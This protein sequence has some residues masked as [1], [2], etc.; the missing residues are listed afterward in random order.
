M[1]ERHRVLIRQA[2][3]DNSLESVVE[4]IF[5]AFPVNVAGKRVLVKPNILA[6]REPDKAVTTHPAVVSAVIRSLEKRRA[7]EIIVGDNGGMT[8]YGTNE[9][10][11]AKSGLLEA[12]GKHYRNLGASPV[13]VPLHNPYAYD[14]AIS[15]EILDCD[16]LVS[17]PKFKTHTLTMISCAIKNSYGFLLG[18]E[19]ARL[20]R[21]AKSKDAFARTIVDVFS[22][23]M[24]DLVICDGIL[25]MQ[26]NGPSSKDV[27]HLGRLLASTDA[28]ALDAVVGAMMGLRPSEVRTTVEAAGRGLGIADIEALEIDGAVTPIEGFKLPGTLLRGRVVDWLA[29]FISGAIVSEPRPDE[30]TC[31]RCGLC[32]DHCPTEAIRMDPY[33]KIAREKCIRCY[34]C[35]EFCPHDAMKLSRR[36]RFIRRLAR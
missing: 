11:A 28:V 8:E 2:E 21:V 26:G 1:P 23:R 35:L 16:V 4:E 10:A 13:R 19:K 20:H 36:V 22:L 14:V 34:C 25:A 9:E 6:G 24:P 27:F 30:D 12:A 5:E 3:Y 17:L 33:P 32:R 15:K 29:R 7:A 18:G 31:V